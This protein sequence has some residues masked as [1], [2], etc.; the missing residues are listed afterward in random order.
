MTNENIIQNA[1]TVS[2]RKS[3]LA[4]QALNKADVPK[5][6]ARGWALDAVVTVGNGVYNVIL[7]RDDHETSQDA[8]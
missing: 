1:R 7:A 6:L 8:R 4:V 3:N 2:I 5:Y